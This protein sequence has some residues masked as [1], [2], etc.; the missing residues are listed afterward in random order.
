M[1]GGVTEAEDSAVGRGH[2]VPVLVAGPGDTHNRRVQTRIG[3]RTQEV[4]VPVG[5]DATARRRQPVATVVVGVD[6]GLNRAA[7]KA[8]RLNAGQRAH[9]LGGP[10]VEDPT[11]VALQPVAEGEVPGARYDAGAGLEAG[12]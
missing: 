1:E 9:E 8:H 11:V 6:R 7:H 10:V 12:R 4:R 3:Q 2:P 5:E